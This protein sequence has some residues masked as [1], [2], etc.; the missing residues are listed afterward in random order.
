MSKNKISL[1][2]IGFVTTLAL[3]ASATTGTGYGTLAWMSI[4]DGS[5]TDP[6][7]PNYQ[8]QVFTVSTSPT[9][10]TCKTDAVRGGGVLYRIPDTAAGD[11]MRAVIMAAWL[12]GKAM[13]VYVNDSAT[14]GKDANGVCY[15]KS[16]KV[17][18]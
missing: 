3:S 1:L 16:V 4:G 8:G 15:A 6:G 5:T 10:T 14:G 18:Q 7:L 2:A 17:Q 9:G 13:T 11:R 12:A